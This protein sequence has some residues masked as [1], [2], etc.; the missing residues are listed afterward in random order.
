MMGIAKYLYDKRAAVPEDSFE[1]FKKS[2]EANETYPMSRLY[3]AHCYHDLNKYDEALRHYSLVDSDKLLTEMPPWRY[4]KM[5][6]QMGHCLSKLGRL[7]ESRQ[8]L[9]RALEGYNIYPYDEMVD[10]LEVYDSL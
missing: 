1:Y 9:E 8:F 2:V 10:P 5:C 7:E 3:L 6:E 4:Y